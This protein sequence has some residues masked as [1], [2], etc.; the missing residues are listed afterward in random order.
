VDKI[1]LTILGSGSRGNCA[2][3]EAP[4]VS[5]LVDAGLSARQIKERLHLIGKEVESIDGI[6]LTHEHV[7]HINAL[8]VLTK[9]KDIP[10][11][12]NSYTAKIVRER[13]PVFS[14]WRIFKTGDNLRIGS[15]DVSAFSIPHDACDPVG[16]VVSHKDHTVGFVTDLGYATKLVVDRIK[17]CSVLLLETNHDISLLKADKKRPWPVKQ[18]I[19]ARHGH[20]SNQT[21]ASAVEMIASDR[22]RHLFLGHLSEDCNN[23][24]LA[25]SCIVG[26]LE[27]KNAMH[28]CIHDTFQHKSASTLELD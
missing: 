18:R 22:L 24:E 12:A 19:M 13:I 1:R 14:N 26:G 6:L 17:N 2:Y 8:P 15:L 4:D 23:L 7:D 25:R 11:Y 16:Y 5:I 28:V 10:I 20:L 9:K 21:A 3:L 27:R